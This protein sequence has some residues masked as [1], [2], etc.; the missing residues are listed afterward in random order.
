VLNV[1]KVLISYQCKLEIIRTVEIPISFWSNAPSGN[2]KIEGTLMLPNNISSPI[3]GVVLIAGSGGEDRW[4]SFSIAYWKFQAVP[5]MTPY[6]DYY[7]VSGAVFKDIGN[8]LV[9]QK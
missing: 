5:P 7:V 9:S 3:P 8:Y 1:R 2:I 6:C 4:E